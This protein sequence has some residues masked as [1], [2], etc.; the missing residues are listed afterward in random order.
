M[1]LANPEGVSSHTS[2]K[3]NLSRVREPQRVEE[4]KSECPGRPHQ[5]GFTGH[6]LREG[7]PRRERCWRAL[8]GRPA[9]PSWA[10]VLACVRENPQRLG[11]QPPKRNRR[12]PWPIHVNVWQKPLQYCKVISLQLIKEKK[13]NRRESSEIIWHCLSSQSERKTS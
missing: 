3:G 8:E 13:R 10:L 1:A 11:K 9:L 5:Q 7:E 4:R 6:S 12:N 2:G